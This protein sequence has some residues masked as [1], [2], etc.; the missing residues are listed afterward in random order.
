MY[1]QAG[2]DI[3]VLS[4]FPK[5]YSGYFLELGCNHPSIFNNTLLLEQK[6]GWEGVNIDIVD[7]SK[8]WESRRSQFICADASTCDFNSF[9]LPKVIDYLSL[10]VDDLGM[11][12]FVLNRILNYGF[13]FRCITVEHN[14]YLGKEYNIKERNPQRQLLQDKEYL[15]VKKDVHSFTNTLKFEDWWINPYFLKL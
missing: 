4:L 11:N 2:Q 10:D 14:S 7:Y 9:K 1:S 3:W 8:E 15:L 6:E 13:I 12:Y 5:G